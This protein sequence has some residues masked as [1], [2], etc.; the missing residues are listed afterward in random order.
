MRWG[1]DWGKRKSVRVEEAERNL[2]TGGLCVRVGCEFGLSCAAPTPAVVMVQP[3]LEC[4]HLI[5]R[6]EWK[7]QPSM[8]FRDGVDAFGN[9]VRRLV[10]P[11]GDVSLRYDAVLMASSEP[12]ATDTSVGQS[13]PEDLPDDALL[14]LLPSRYC[15][16][17]ALADRA[18]E[19]F[20]DVQPG[21]SRV[22]AI[23]DWVH[24][25]INFDYGK[26]H[27][28][29]TAVDTFERREGVCRDFTHL[30]VAFCR[31]VNIPARYAFGYLPDID[32]P[33]L[34][35]PMD[36]C[37]WMEVL[38]EGRWWTFDPRNNQRRIAHIVIGRG[39]DA[40]DVPMIMTFGKATLMRMTVWADQIE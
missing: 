29:M 36:F 4:G 8:T 7:T 12:D 17:D 10:L 18:W 34:D 30:A 9:E 19:L 39:R 16:S 24:G 14:Y 2:V 40:A 37:A 22:Q 35:A 21:W 20:A 15:E 38:L 1:G 31:A 13:A 5:V 26:S 6:E 33:P 25:S 23:S 27:P 28:T 3:K 32:V 11:E